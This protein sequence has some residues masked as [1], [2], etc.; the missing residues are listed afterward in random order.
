M[1]KRLKIILISVLI[2]ITTAFIPTPYYLYQPGPIEELSSK[3]Q[4]QNGYE[5]EKGSF[6]LTTVLTSKASNIYYLVYGLLAPHTEIK[7]VEEVQ[8]DL[9]EKEYSDRLEFMMKDSK[10]NA[11]VSAFSKAGIEVPIQYHGIF[12]M[13]V[14]PKSKAK[15][16]LKVGDTITK[17][18]G[19]T[20]NEVAA[21]TQYIS[22]NKNVNDYVELTILRNGKEINKKVEVIQLD[23]SSQKLGLG[24]QPEEDF[25]ASISKD[26]KINSDDIGGPSAGLMFSLEIYNQLTPNDLTKG[27]KIAGTGAIDHNGNVGQIG[28]IT[29]KLTAANQEGVDIFFAPKD[30]NPIDSNEKDAKSFAEKYESSMK[31]VP[32]ATLSEAINYLEGIKEK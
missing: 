24:I 5:N 10:Q 27:Y 17:V 8:G 16:I 30:I 4:V 32:V 6:N 26:V 23:P 3:V 21:F 18:D 20:V 19:Q 14:Q 28:G 15:G 11:L 22:D 7:K 13:Y 2:L 31:I 25:T 1:K 9:S 12:V 29:H